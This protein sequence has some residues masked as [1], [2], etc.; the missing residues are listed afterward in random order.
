M[1]FS[2][3]LSFAPKQRFQY[4]GLGYPSA[5]ELET[6]VTDHRGGLGLSLH[7]LFASG[8]SPSGFRRLAGHCAV[9]LSLGLLFSGSLQRMGSFKHQVVVILSCSPTLC[10]GPKETEDLQPIEVDIATLYRPGFG[11]GCWTKGNMINLQYH[12]PDFEHD[13][14][15]SLDICMLSMRSKTYRHLL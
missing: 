14:C 15:I 9:P 7:Q 8:E 13:F 10:L 2:I 5:E 6:T 3:K 4:L 1:S 11:M 12:D